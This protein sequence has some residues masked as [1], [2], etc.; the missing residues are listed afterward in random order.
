M[1]FEKG[2]VPHRMTGYHMLYV[3]KWYMPEKL[4]K[5]IKYRPDY[6]SIWRSAEE[7]VQLM[8]SNSDNML[9]MYG[10]AEELTM[11]FKIFQ[12]F[13][14]SH[15]RFGYDQANHYTTIPTVY[16]SMNGV[17]FLNKADIFCLFQ[18]VVVGN[19]FENPK[20]GPVF[21]SMQPILLKSHEEIIKGVCEFFKYDKDWL[22][23]LQDEFPQFHKN[24][25]ESSTIH[26][27]WNF[28]KA[29][30]M[31]KTLLPVWNEQGYDQFEFG[32]KSFFDSEGADIHEV[33][34]VI[35][36]LASYLKHSISMFPEMFQ[37]YDEVK[38]PNSPIVVRVFEFHGVQFVMKSEFFN[39]IKIRNPDLRRLACRDYDGKLMTMSYEKVQ[40]KYKDR[41]ENI[42]FIKCPIERATHKAVPTMTPS[43]EHCIL[44]VDFLFEMLN[45]LIF[46]HRIFQKVESENLNF[47]RRFFIKMTDFFS[48]HHQSIFFVTLE[49]QDETNYQFLDYWENFENVDTKHVR[50]FGEDGFTVQDLKE[51]LEYL[52]LTKTFPEIQDYAES[53][54]SEVFKAK[55]GGFL[56]TCD[57]YTAVEKCLLNCVFRR[58]PMLRLFLHTQKACHLLPELI[59]DFCDSPNKKQFKNTNWKEPHYTKT[60]STY[61]K[62]D[63][64]NTYLYEIKLPDG[65][66]LTNSY[67]RFFNME[68]IRKHNIKYFIYDQND[69]IHFSKNSRTLKPRKL[70]DEC[71]YSLDAF[72]NFF[73]EKKLY[74]RTIPSVREKRNE[75]KR[76]FVEE[77][78]ELISV[79]LRQQN[80]RIEESDDR[81][82][83]Y[84]KKWE[85]N[86]KA[87]EKT[88][89]LTEFW[90]ILEE[91]DV[92][93]TRITII[94]DP[95]YQLTVPK[96]VKDLRIRTLNMISPRGE[97]V[98][99]SEQ[100][101]YHIFEVVYCGLNWTKD[102]CRTHENC[103]KELKTKMI[104]SM[105]AYSEMDEGTYVTV[106]HVHSVIKQLKN[107][108]SF[109]LQRKTPSPLVELQKRKCDEMISMEEF[110]SKCQKIGLT[111]TMS[112]MKLFLEPLTMAFVVRIRYLAVF[113][114]EF[115]D[116]G[117]PD[118]HGLLNVE[119]QLKAFTVAESLGFK[120]LDDIL[121]LPPH[122]YLTSM[123]PDNFLK[124]K[125]HVNAAAEKNT[126]P[127]NSKTEE[128][129]TSQKALA[130]A[131]E[132]TEEPEVEKNS[133]DNK[134]GKEDFIRK[135]P[136]PEKALDVKKSSSEDAQKT[137]ES[138]KALDV[139]TAVMNISATD[140]NQSKCCT[141]CL[142][143]S[144]MCNEAKKE[145]KMT[146][147][148]LEK[149]EKKAKR[150][151]EVEIQM[152]E[153]EVEMKRMKK[154]MKEREL[155][156]EKK[157]TEM[158]DLKR[159]M[160]KLEAKE[161]KMQLA[162]KNHSISQNELLEKITELSDQSKAEKE[163]IDELMAQLKSEKERMELQI[164]QNEERLNSEIREKERGF[165]EL[166]AALS[167][168]STEMESIQRDNR[169][170]R[171]QI[172]SI[173]ESPPTPPVP[174]SPSE[175]S[176]HH[177][178]ALL[179][180]QKIKDSLYH[181]KQLKQAKE[182]IE[183]LKS[184]SNL[185]EIHQIADYE[186]YQFEAKLL[187]YSKEV[188][189][190]IQRIKETC[191]VSTVTPLPDFPEFSKRFMNLYWRIIN[192]QSVT[193]S[194]I[195]VSDSECFICTEEMISDQKTLECEEC[196]K[197][198]HFE[199]A[200]KWLKI[201]RSCPHC[202]REMLDPNE[203]PNLGQ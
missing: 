139:K 50:N 96:L 105:R 115:L 186:Y 123:H 69:M 15:K 6:E 23:R 17:A 74:I 42:E 192:N 114:D 53:V 11:N 10:T 155:T 138:E 173:P 31:F 106:E 48:P 148:R 142:R 8:L 73:P 118:L 56:R 147:S 191:D 28:E 171:D 9:Q 75:T 177:R 107:H 196:K 129:K 162:E 46:T 18:N 134:N 44:A 151:E 200:S 189:L 19:P 144:E 150:T 25:Q 26:E 133:V 4:M 100:A 119:M 41:I 113:L 72:Q 20:S 111:K 90:Y 195:E 78:L 99:R 36:S 93:K 180:F 94:P 54:H 145:L 168:M 47:L 81:L 178:F 24:A 108:C 146:Q 84:R 172:A 110:I 22:R 12:N 197:V 154:E 97:Q 82:E 128:S 160:L 179:G 164:Q 13:P 152:R 67:N 183:K 3:M 59:C 86:D 158:E 39:A 65:T 169:N 87:L 88:I 64:E 7:V 132:H 159:N 174:E 140:I 141:K 35:Q 122:K 135:T 201:H 62:S 190:N 79:V 170:L 167:I 89:S 104:C 2:I 33:A 60:S 103:L 95:V 185:V 21:C 101:V 161:A 14:L 37:P 193:S 153:M 80:T 32:L 166:R 57:M 55:K 112:N 76:V 68:Q 117:R 181:K 203:F 165:E 102:S 125:P 63:P 124:K 70:R 92:D 71:R 143:T 98:M 137:S 194:E 40:R 34:Q 30:K 188:E 66:Q 163:I 16:E 175:R 136:V 109:Q 202:R 38:N 127:K 1:N 157:D 198:T 120:G 45:E 27:D 5:S 131:M 49:E 184:S 126:P 199:C 77:V 121:N 29:L 52:G 156:M 58:F 176:T 61:T 187:K 83:K 85:T 130:V 43:G 149:Y 51:E 91:F 182:M 116:L